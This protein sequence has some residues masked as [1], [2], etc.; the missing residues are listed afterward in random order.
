MNSQQ[1]WLNN[2]KKIIRL[3]KSGEKKLKFSPWKPRKKAAAAGTCRF[4]DTSAKLKRTPQLALISKYINFSNCA[5]DF[6]L[7]LSFFHTLWPS[8]SLV[9]LDQQFVV[10]CTQFFFGFFLFY[11]AK[12]FQ[13]GAQL[14]GSSYLLSSSLLSSLSFPITLF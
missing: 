13:T 2:N 7:L 8:L 1:Y 10:V 9:C 11:Q 12:L 3:Q 14:L 5:K 6:Y 4:L